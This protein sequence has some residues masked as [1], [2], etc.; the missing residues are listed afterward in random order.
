MTG[1]KSLLITGDLASL[2]TTE[3]ERV[4]HLRGE[5]SGD[6]FEIKCVSCDVLTKNEYL[7]GDPAVPHFKATC[8]KCGES[9]TLKLSHHDWQS[10]PLKL[11]K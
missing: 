10:W 2:L 9:I 8:G 6:H 4:L 3:E 1:E 7:G 5:D 11:T